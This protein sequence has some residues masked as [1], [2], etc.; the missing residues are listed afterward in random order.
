MLKKFRLPILALAT[1]LALGAPASMFAR[2]YHHHGWREHRHHFGVGVYVGP[3]P[4][5]GYYSPYYG[6]YGYYDA[7]GYW[8]P[9]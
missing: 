1:V 4:Y 3:T 6:P 8:H 7:W 9:Y 5:Y 2:D